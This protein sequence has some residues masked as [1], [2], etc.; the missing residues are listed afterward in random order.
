MRPRRYGTLNRAVARSVTYSLRGYG[1]K[2]KRN[3]Y[4]YENQNNINSTPPISNSI[5][6]IIES[7][8]LIFVLIFAIQYPI[9]WILYFVLLFSI[10]NNK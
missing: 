2:P 8:L 9:L 1:K 6:I 7:I 4:T 3:N 5:A 10:F